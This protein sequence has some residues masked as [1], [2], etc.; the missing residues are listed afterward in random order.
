LTVQKEQFWMKELSGVSVDVR[1]TV[2]QKKIEGSLLFAHKGI[3]G[4]AVLNTSLY[5]KKGEITVDFLPYHNIN[6]LLKQFPNKQ[7]TTVLGL[8]KRFS[9]KFLEVIGVADKQ[10]KKVLEKEKQKLQQ[11]HTYRFAPAGNFGFSKAE[12]SL[13]GVCTDALKENFESKDVASLYF[14]GEGVDVTGELGGYN[15]QWAFASGVVCARGL[16]KCLK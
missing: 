12:V 5:W 2:A 11:I 7:I 15:F 9:K 1:I 13:G 3:S 4:P 6:Q 16:Q 8:P 14:I 10:C